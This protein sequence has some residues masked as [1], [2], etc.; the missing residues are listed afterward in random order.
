M[1]ENDGPKL[2]AGK[3]VDTYKLV[4]L[5]FSN[6]AFWSVIFKSCIFQV[7]LFCGLSFSGTINSALSTVVFC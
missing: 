2:R 6:L 3:G 5:V 1:Q 4:L 7:L